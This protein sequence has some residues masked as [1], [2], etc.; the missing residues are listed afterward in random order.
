[1]QP[2]D[3]ILHGLFI[4]PV[5]ANCSIYESGRMIYETLLISNK[6]TLDY[7]EINEENRNVPG[8]YDFYAFNYHYITMGWLDTR[9][10]RSLPGLKIT[11]VLEILPNN[12]FILCPS[13][14]F[15]VYCALD[16]TMNVPDKRVYT[17]PRPLEIPKQLS[18]FH[19]P[20]IPV[21]GSF[22]FATTGKGF[23]QVVDAV[24]KE[25]N[26]AVVRIN[27]PPGTYT[28]D[29]RSFAKYLGD[30]CI[31]TAKKGVEVIITHDYMTKD[32]LIEWCGQN[33]LNCFLYSRNMPGLSATTDQAI[34]SGRPLSVSNNET[35]RHITQYIKP[36]PNWSLK[37]SI[38]H[39]QA[40]V[41]QMKKD[42]APEIFTNKFEQLLVDF[43]CFSRFQQKSIGK[44]NIEL[45]CKQP[46]KWYQVVM[47]DIINKFK[48]HVYNNDQYEYTNTCE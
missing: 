34:S 32:E 33:T 47:R 16:P 36:Y 20:Q 31:K 41:L 23:E 21:I 22:G 35:F 38:S 8:N 11:F 2:G 5:K 45:I 25:F 42:W 28:D 43:T 13:K 4:N 6:Y 44:N 26:E 30:L 39:S 1:M 40:G 24:N 9:S 10:V 37:E 15:D 17:F 19:E 48:L 29:D 7:L 14:D 3:N 27:I 12:P 46:Q 18:P